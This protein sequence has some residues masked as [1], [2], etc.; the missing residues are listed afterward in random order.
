MGA[1]VSGKSTKNYT[2][3][4]LR[5]IAMVCIIA[6]HFFQYY[7]SEWAWWF[8]VGVQMFFC[9]SGF[10]YGHKRIT[11]PVDFICNT[12]K[13]IL[14]PYFCF[15]IPVIGLYFV[16]HRE[17]LS[18]SS[19]AYALLTADTIEGLGHLWFISYILFC[20]LLTPYLQSVAKKLKKLPWPLFVCACAVLFVGGFVLSYAFDSYFTFSR[21]FCYLVGYFGAVFLQ[22]YGKKIGALLVYGFAGAA[23][24]MNTVRVVCLY[25][26][27]CT[28]PLFDWFV[29]YAHA[30]LGIAIVLVCV[31]SIQ[32]IKQHTF[33]DITDTYS[34][35]VYIVHLV[36]ILSPFTLLEITP[37][38]VVNG[39]L[40]LAA[41]LLAT[42]LLKRIADAM[43]R[44]I[45]V[46]TG[47]VKKKAI[48]P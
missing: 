11:S 14:I 7:G 21:V 13:K 39:G 22:T 42:I 27:P 36:F 47:A 9:I 6:C 43:Q 3:S 18:V 4:L 44:A 40:A 1:D 38:P 5:C 32:S 28:F 8:N 16:F 19:V 10:L 37:Y 15:L 34:F 46:I 20:Y 23:L 24:L 33:L 17:M 25:I 45:S 48:R 35:Y 29:E 31:V 26:R 2:I 30:F 12:F 41:I